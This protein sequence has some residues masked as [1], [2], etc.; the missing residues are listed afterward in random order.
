MSQN[1]TRRASS[2][3]KALAIAAVFAVLPSLAL[4]TASTPSLAQ[5]DRHAKVS[6]LV[7]TLF[8]RSHYRQI[9]V[10]DAVSSRIL[11]RYIEAMDGNRHYFL[12]GDIAEFETYRFELD[13]AVKRGELEP[14]FS[15]YD[16]YLQRTR[17]RLN[18]ALS[19]LDEEPDFS[20][21]EYYE[22]E[23]S[24]APWATSSDELD[25]LWRKR[26]KNDAL[27]LLLADK[28]WDESAEI[29]EKRYSRV[30][31]RTEQI[32]SDDVFEAFMNA[33]SHTLDP[34]SS[35]FSP[36]NSEEYRIQMSLSYDGIGASLQTED[37][38]VSILNVIPGGPAAIE[39][40]LKPK[41]RITAVGQGSDGE[42]VDVVG[43]RLDEVVEL[44]RGPGGTVVRLQILPAGAAPGN[45]E[46]ILP[47]TRD[48]IKLEAQAAQKERIEVERDGNKL[49]VGVITVPSFYQDFNAR[50]AG[51]KDYT[52][53]TKDVQRLIGELE[54]EGIDGLVL[55]LR[56][57]GGGHLSEATALT[58]LFVDRG[59]IVQLRNTN[60]RIEVLEDPMP[61]KVYD[62]PLA[63]LVNR[64]S[65]SASEIFAAAIQDYNRGIIIGQQTFGKGTVQN[66]Y[67]LDRYAPGRDPQFGQLTLTIGKYYRVTGGST[68]HK[69]VIPD[70]ELP[71]AVDTDIIGESSR[72]SALPWDQIEA[73]K[74][75]AS[76][77]LQAAVSAL[78]DSY[79]DR[80]QGNPD[81]V[82][83]LG[84]IEEQK[85]GQAHREISLSIEKRRQEREEATQRSL[86]RV[87]QR[88]AALG[89]EPA[90]KLEEVP[91]N[92]VP[93]VILET[94]ADLVADMSK[95]SPPAM[96]QNR[97]P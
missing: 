37:D 56:N 88:R 15:M 77:P 85:T 81:Y 17:E 78:T 25:E 8:E 94:A 90:E 55:D 91:D 65:A 39:G 22:F 54:E 44:I 35:Y 68:Q 83:L 79:H 89:L 18:F 80:A 24:E 62:G 42:M 19:M 2:G 61:D 84:E 51:E 58:G 86:D 27:S 40:S 34:H 28:T 52:S 60:G 43:W 46:R 96:A 9:R 11:D 71:S 12:A 93:D 95:L 21:D 38:Y 36:R 23:R 47:L 67:P 30:L 66:L 69:G 72:D 7:T 16:R 57:N 5:S 33:Y 41:D 49:H 32:N 13:D 26:V 97:T 1:L 87:N 10:D 14:V 82:Y 92:E 45:A 29:L 6:R 50:A 76:Q 48:K 70:I 3:L 63:V 53:T 64:F 75:R 31:K 4:G 20:V 73:T 59:P 74:Y